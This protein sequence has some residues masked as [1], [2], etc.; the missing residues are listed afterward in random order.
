[1]NKTSFEELVDKLASFKW[2]G[3]LDQADQFSKLIIELL[4]RYADLQA[5]KADIENAIKGAMDDNPN[6]KH[7]SCV[8]LFKVK[9]KQ[10]EA[11]LEQTT[12][13]FDSFKEHHK[14]S[15]LYI[16]DLQAEINNKDNALLNY[17]PLVEHLQEKVSNLECCGS[18]NKSENGGLGFVC[19]LNFNTEEP[20]H[21]CPSYQ[22]DELTKGER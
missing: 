8:P 4:T 14:S 1:M 6:E 17:P 20:N 5:Y 18:C 21:V 16:I 15:H 22:P 7:C 10:L 3:S 12:K 19:T 9:I 13:C 11:E 2:D